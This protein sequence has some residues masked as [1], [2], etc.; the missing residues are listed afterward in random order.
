MLS[1]DLFL[2]QVELEETQNHTV[3]AMGE[4]VEPTHTFV[5]PTHDVLDCLTCLVEVHTIH[6]EHVLKLQEDCCRLFK[7]HN[8]NEHSV[9]GG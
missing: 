9:E 6:S 7:E 4:I 2:H 1:A 5:C 8:S 3:V